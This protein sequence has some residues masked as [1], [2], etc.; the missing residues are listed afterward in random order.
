MTHPGGI[1]VDQ[2]YQGIYGTNTERVEYEE[3]YGTNIERGHAAVTQCDL[4]HLTPTV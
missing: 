4:R 1:S 2:A 3:R